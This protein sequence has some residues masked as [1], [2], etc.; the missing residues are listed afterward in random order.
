MKNE[1]KINNEP[2]IKN[3]ASN[4]LLGE[5]LSLKEAKQLAM[6]GGKKIRHRFFMN[7]L[8]GA[9]QIMQTI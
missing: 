5:V 4:L 6:F 1:S 8:T 9:L 3:M 7:G 2:A